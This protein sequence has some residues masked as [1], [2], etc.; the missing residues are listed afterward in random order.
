MTAPRRPRSAWLLVGST[1]SVWVWVKAQSA[2]QRLRRLLANCRW[3]FVLGLLRVACSSSWRSLCSSGACG[4][5]K[6]GSGSGT[7]ERA[8]ES[9]ARP[10]DSEEL[11][12]FWSLCYL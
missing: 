7:C 3:Y 11:F 1:P 12:L 5:R 4:V 6:L 10:A 8:V 2:G 9:C